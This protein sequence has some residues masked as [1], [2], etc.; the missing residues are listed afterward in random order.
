MNRNELQRLAQQRIQE[1]KVLLAAKQWSGAYYLAGY[2]VE[3]GLKSC[4]LAFIERTGIIF[5][6]K[7]YGERCW[8]HELDRLMKLAGL[9]ADLGVAVAAN[10]VRGENWAT[11]KGWSEV[12]RYRVTPH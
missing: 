10:P 7:N 11:V 3:C 12:R 4:I 2:A 5:E 1:A 9:E 8:T 6:E